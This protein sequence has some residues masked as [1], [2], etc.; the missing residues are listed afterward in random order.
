[1]RS[2][3]RSAGRRQRA[4]PQR[5]HLLLELR[6]ERLARFQEILETYDAH[7]GYYGHASVGCLHVRPM[8]NLKEASE[9]EKMGVHR[10]PVGTFARNNA[11]VKGY[12]LLCN[13]LLERL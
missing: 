1:M 11:A 6:F 4:R 7:G 8:I 9:V 10:A 3:W 13:E 2:S 12:D 5:R